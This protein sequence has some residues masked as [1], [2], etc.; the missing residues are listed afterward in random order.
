M[1]YFDRINWECLVLAW[2]RAGL[3]VGSHADTCRL[4]NPLRVAL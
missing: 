3:V 2:L 1:N 4:F